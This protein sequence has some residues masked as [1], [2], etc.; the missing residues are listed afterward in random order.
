M[1]AVPEALRNDSGVS[2][3]EVVATTNS[4]RVVEAEEEVAW[5]E[6]N[7]HGEVVPKPTRESLLMM[8]AVVEAL[9][10]VVEPIP[11]T[12]HMRGRLESEEVAESEKRAKGEVDEMPKFFEEAA[13]KKLALSWFSTPPA[14]MKGTEPAVNEVP[15]LPLTVRCPAMVEVA[16]VPLL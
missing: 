1:K 12:I 8:R 11:A 5:I 4:G 10:G 16:V 9:A 3:S 15:R 6:T 2:W 7:P 14:P 13:Q